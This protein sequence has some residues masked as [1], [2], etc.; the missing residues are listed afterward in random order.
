MK[1]SYLDH[2]FNLKEY[3]FPMENAEYL[4]ELQT[5]ENNNTVQM[6][7]NDVVEIITKSNSFNV[8]VDAMDGINKSL[9]YKSDSHGEK[10]NERVAIFS[11]AMGVLQ[12][13]N[14]ENLKVALEAAKYHDIGR[15]DDE[16]D[17]AH[18]TRSAELIE[19]NGIGRDLSE[20]SRKILKAICM[21]H[22]VDDQHIEQIRNQLRNKR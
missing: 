22:S 12:N 8:F 7:I 13:L 15:K 6:H 17:A 1:S 9:L 18:G 16:E 20:E 21:G 19:A 14:E 2:F 3:T 11:M 4:R 10:H 5:A